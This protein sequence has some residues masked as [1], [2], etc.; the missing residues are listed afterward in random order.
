MA[1]YANDEGTM[2]LTGFVY[3]ANDHN[4]DGDL[5]GDVDSRIYYRGEYHFETEFWYPWR[6]ALTFCIS[7]CTLPC[8]NEKQARMRKGNTKQQLSERPL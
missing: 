4:S 1:N 8:T 5:P 6:A 3:Q 2:P 7:G